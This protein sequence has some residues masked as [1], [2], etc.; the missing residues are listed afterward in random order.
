MR[1]DRYAGLSRSYP[2]YFCTFESFRSC[3]LKQRKQLRRE[4]DG[5]AWAGRRGA[6]VA[7]FSWF[8]VWGEKEEGVGVLR[9]VGAP[10]LTQGFP[11]LGSAVPTLLRPGPSCPPRP[12]AAP[13]PH[14]RG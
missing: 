10:V 5:K 9:G 13:S 1:S 12:P 7:N 14:H 3:K 4:R 2:V 11:G 8:S 6:T